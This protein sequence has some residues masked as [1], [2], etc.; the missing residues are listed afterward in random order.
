M[1]RSRD[2]FMEIRE[3]EVQVDDYD[4]QY[5]QWLTDAQ[6]K[7]EKQK[8]KITLIKK[9]KEDGTLQRRII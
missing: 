7:V 2:L 8:E 9:T 4:Y 3:K 5:F 6:W 1:S